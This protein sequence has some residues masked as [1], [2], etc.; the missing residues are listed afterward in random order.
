MAGDYHKKFSPCFSDRWLH[1]LTR[2]VLYVL[3]EQVGRGDMVLTASDG[4]NAWSGGLTREQL[5]G[6]ARYVVMATS[7]ALTW[8]ISCNPLQSTDGGSSLLQCLPS[9]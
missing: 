3:V 9:P 8:N 2:R 4:E 1:P 5:S 6:M 7:H